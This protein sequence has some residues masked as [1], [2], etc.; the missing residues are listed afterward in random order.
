MTFIAIER[1][2]HIPSF[3]KLVINVQVELDP[4]F[5]E[6]LGKTYSCL[7]IQG[8]YSSEPQLMPE[9]ADNPRSQIHFFFLYIQTMVKFN[10]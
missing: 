8:I 1:C 4:I 5:K 2:L 3:K 10:L 7:L 6:A 9:T